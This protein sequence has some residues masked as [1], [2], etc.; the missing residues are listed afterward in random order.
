MADASFPCLFFLEH[1]V[2]VY[3]FSSCEVMQAKSSCPDVINVFISQ[4]GRSGVKD[5]ERRAE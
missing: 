3:M 5:S 1:S 4:Q 2:S